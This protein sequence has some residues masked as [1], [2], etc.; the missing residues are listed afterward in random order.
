DTIDQLAIELT[1]NLDNIVR[2]NEKHLKSINLSN[3][4]WIF[5]ESLINLLTL[6]E[7]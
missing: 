4:K 3:S 7:E 2:K 6:F 5:I 1:H